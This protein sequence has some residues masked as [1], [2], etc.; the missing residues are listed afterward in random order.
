MPQD[1]VLAR[2]N[3]FDESERLQ[4]RDDAA[5]RRAETLVKEDRLRVVLVTM[6]AGVESNEHS[7]PG[8][9]SIQVLSGRF[10][11]DCEGETSE[12]GAGDLISLAGNADHV[13]R[14]T[15]DGAFLLTIGWGH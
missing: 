15:E 9:I 13:V 8:P 2:V 12:L 10:E 14:A 5:G 4:P 11:V 6:R 7:T 3:L 1:A